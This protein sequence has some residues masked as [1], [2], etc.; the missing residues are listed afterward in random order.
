MN[1]KDV[2]ISQEK[3]NSFKERGYLSDDILPKTKEQRSMEK[4]NYF[5]LWMGSVHN[6]PNYTA[7]GGFLALGLAPIHVIIA[8]ILAGMAISALMAYNGRAGSKYGIP[9]SMHLRSVFGNVGAK[10]PGFL[11]GVVAAIAWFGV[12][13][14]AG[15]QALLVLVGKAWPAFLEIGGDT[16]ILGLSVPA[17]ISFIVFFLVNIAIGLGGGDVLNK[18]TAFISPFIYI[19]FGGMVIWGLRVAGGFGAIL[20]Y[21]TT[22]TTQVNPIFAYLMIIA[23]SL[24]V[25]AAP[26]VS[27]ADFTQNAESTEDQ[28]IGQTGSLL[29]AY[30][31]YAFAAVIILTVGSMQGINH[32]GAILDIINTW[33]ST[34]S[35]FLASFVLL[36]TTVSTNA[37]G[38]IIPAAYQLTALFPKYIDYRKGVLL[39]SAISFIIMPWKFMQSGGLFLTFLN[40]IGALLGPV[41]GVMI[42]HFYFISKQ[43]ID[44]DELYVDL[45]QEDD[46]NYRGINYNGYIAMILGFLIT[47]SGE[48]IPALSALSQI[49][50]IMGFGVGFVV[51]LVMSKVRPID[52]YTV[53]FEAKNI[54]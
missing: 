25:W 37:T 13:N 45:D 30:T 2:Y 23:S 15:S 28:V 41:A 7:V 18:F 48:F 24:S 46:S 27:V 1:E 38:N 6:I 44:I 42:A 43:E 32:D 47:V 34:F 19:V 14:Y 40:L 29:V 54:N 10:L 53:D 33:D 11:R 4:K 8:I 21:A 39:A 5:T 20:N 51:Y 17:M 31:M 9:F 22:A 12:Q 16:S 52:R 50:W 36:A 49:G 3:V 35:I 26:G